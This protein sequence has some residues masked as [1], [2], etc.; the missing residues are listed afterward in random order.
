MQ[1]TGKEVYRDV[2]GGQ[3]FFKPLL[4]SLGGESKVPAT[5]TTGGGG[6]MFVD[7][8]SASIDDDD[9]GGRSRAKGDTGIACG[10]ALALRA[11]APV[12]VK[13]SPGTLAAV[14]SIL[15]FNPCNVDGRDAAGVV[16][17]SVLCGVEYC[18]PAS[19]GTVAGGEL[20][21]V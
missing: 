3:F 10:G 15:L 7:E 16:P 9:G 20:D 2:I 6:S 11:T 13:R 12:V 19:R 14:A 4:S 17:V 8:L 18:V 1:C 5:I 21:C